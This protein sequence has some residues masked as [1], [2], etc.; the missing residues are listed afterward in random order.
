MTTPVGGINFNE[1]K[2]VLLVGYG[3]SGI[4]VYKFLSSRGHKVLAIDDSDASCAPNTMSDI[5]W[6]DIDVVVKSPSVPI[7]PH[8]R[9][10]SIAQATELQ[11]P[12]VSTFDVFKLHY[13]DA[14]IVAVTGTNGKSTTTSLIFHILHEAGFSV[15]IGGNIGIPYFDMGYGE[16]YV[17][18][19]SSYELASSQM[20]DFQIACVLNIDPDHYEFHGTFEN[21]ISAKH[22]VLNHAVSKIISC[23]DRYTMS[24]FSAAQDVTVVSTLNNPD[25]DVYLHENTLRDRKSQRLLLDF[26]GISNLLGKHNHQN[27]AM[28]YAAC[29]KLG[30]SSQEIVKSIGSFKPLPHRINILKKVGDIIFVNDSKATNPSSAAKALATFVG[31]EIYW[32]VGGRSKSIDPFPYVNDYLAGVR[33]IYL[34]GE[35]E[36]EF[37]E[38]FNGRKPTVKCGTM[39]DALSLAYRDARREYGQVVVLLSPMCSSFDQFK[40]YEHRGDRFTEIVLALK[41][42]GG[43]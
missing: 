24:K 9:H 12:V 23:E 28:A 41:E 32:L 25:A 30:M 11:I 13:P 42:C 39:D 7:M 1:R 3:I 8:N 38:M 20:L 17:L 26:A 27:I 10:H 43:D 5:M 15:K 19:M 22:E 34:F 40:N 21:Y 18:E 16:Y 33:K 37:A 31:Y 35:S 4:S 6:E 29:R 2:T 36:C 14:K